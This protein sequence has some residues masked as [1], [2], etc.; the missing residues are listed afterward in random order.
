MPDYQAHVT[1]F[2]WLD[3]DT[4]VWAADEGTDAIVGEVDLN[5]S[6]RIWSKAGGPI[7]S[8]LSLTKDGKVAAAVG[9]TPQHPGEVFL[10]TPGA[11]SANGLPSAIRR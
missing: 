9:H 3:S 1:S 6:R 2:G 11:E 5:G 8:S 7:I 10:L 4:L